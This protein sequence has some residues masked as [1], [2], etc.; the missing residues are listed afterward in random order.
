MGMVIAVI[1][2]FQ[3]YWL[4][5]TY[6]RERKA[7]EVRTDALFYETVRQVQDSL[8]EEKWESFTSGDSGTSK[9][10]GKMVTRPFKGPSP[11]QPIR[12]ISRIGQKLVTDSISSRRA[13]ACRRGSSSSSR[14][15]FPHFPS[16][17]MAARRQA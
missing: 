8:W 12:V 7:V 5:D 2:G 1:T 9:M 16:D 10:M 13:P 6:S 17:D 3:V 11:A 14:F 4:K 15:R